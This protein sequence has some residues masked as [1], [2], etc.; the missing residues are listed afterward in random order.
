MSRVLKNFYCV[1]GI[2]GS[3]KTT[4]I[5]RLQE[6]CNSKLK[7]HFTKEPS[8]GVIGEFIRKQLS[9]FKNPLQEIS[10]AHLYTADRYEH[11]YNPRDGIIKIL[12][13]PKTK[14]ITDRYLFS[15]IAYQGDLGQKLNK[16]FPLPEIL[17]FIKTDP[18]IAH[19]RIR[20]TRIQPDLF[21]F[22]AKK[23]HDIS[24][25]Y[26]AL[27]KDLKHSLDVVYIKNSDKK[28]LE[29]GAR[30]IFNLIKF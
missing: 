11:L 1:E 5:Q 18:R 30:Q 24:E 29:I 7:Y 22:E 3:G 17:F 10:L 26:E 4:M 6:L 12:T 19:E 13:K 8:E 16:D 9:N 20:K 25:R 14:V 28:D 23:L 21:E 15:S 27:L 2:D